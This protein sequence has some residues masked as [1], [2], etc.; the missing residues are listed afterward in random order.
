MKLKNAP[1]A[2]QE[3]WRL[4]QSENIQP[5]PYETWVKH[6]NNNKKENFPSHNPPKKTVWDK[7]END[8]LYRSQLELRHRPDSDG[9]ISGNET[10]SNRLVL[11][12]DK[13]N[14]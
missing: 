11:P 14:I 7:I 8:L 4:C 10:M 6:H 13:N 2:F 5:M 1:K 3:Y 12:K 9:F